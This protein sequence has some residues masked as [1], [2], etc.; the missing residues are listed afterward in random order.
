MNAVKMYISHCYLKI[1]AL[2]MLTNETFIKVLMISK[3]KLCTEGS[4]NV[5][6]Q[7]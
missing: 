6:A 5:W 2:T 3:H 4:P 7:S 1:N